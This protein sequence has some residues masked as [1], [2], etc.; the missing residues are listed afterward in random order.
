[1]AA[2]YQPVLSY[3][4]KLLWYAAGF[5][6]LPIVLNIMPRNRNRGETVTILAFRFALTIHY[7]IAD[8]CERVL[9]ECIYEV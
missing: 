8:S 4:F 7:N 6:N 5:K 1:M 9:L 3:M 2:R